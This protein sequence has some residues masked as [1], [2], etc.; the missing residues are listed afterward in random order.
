MIELRKHHRNDLM[1]ALLGSFFF[2]AFTANAFWDLEEY[3]VE[4]FVWFDTDCDGIQDPGEPGVKGLQVQ[5]FECGTTP[6]VQIGNDAN[7]DTAGHSWLNLGISA[8][9]PPAF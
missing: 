4:D 9:A 8:T 7:T 1:L 2:F 5:A 6:P 3:F